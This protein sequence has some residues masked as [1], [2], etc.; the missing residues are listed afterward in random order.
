MEGNQDRH[1]GRE[2]IGRNIVGAFPTPYGL[3][4]ANITIGPQTPVLTNLSSGKLLEAL[5][6]II[7]RGLDRIDCY[8][9]P[10]TSDDAAVIHEGPQPIRRETRLKVVLT[11][12]GGANSTREGGNGHA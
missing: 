9:A 11:F 12:S 4:S 1:D 3:C 10:E 7:E 5:R 8:G 6:M 2:V